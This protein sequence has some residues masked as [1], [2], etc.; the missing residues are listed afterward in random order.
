MSK[1][2]K[3]DKRSVPAGNAVISVKD[4]Q[5]AW[6]IEARLKDWARSH[7]IAEIIARRGPGWKILYVD[8]GVVP[9]EVIEKAVG[10][11]RWTTVEYGTS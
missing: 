9:R 8:Q 3:H 11:Y 6:G 7:G 1:K 10:H 5:C 4:K 2:N